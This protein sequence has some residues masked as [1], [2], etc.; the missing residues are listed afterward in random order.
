MSLSL[1]IDHGWHMGCLWLVVFV[2]DNVPALF[3]CCCCCFFVFLYVFLLIWLF[4]LV[5]FFPA[6]QFTVVHN[7]CFHLLYLWRL[8][9]R[10]LVHVDIYIY[11]YASSQY[12]TMQSADHEKTSPPYAHPWGF[13]LPGNDQHV[14]G[15][16]K[17]GEQQASLPWNIPTL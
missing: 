13:L 4:A 12:N 10:Q 9:I 5:T 2:A 7:M 15:N 6:I 17:I 14:P 11:I 3:P 16:N 1:L 8:V